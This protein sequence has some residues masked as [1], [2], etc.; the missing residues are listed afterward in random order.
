MVVCGK[1][2]L[3]NISPPIAGGDISGRSGGKATQGAG[4]KTMKKAVPLLPVVKVMAAPWRWA[5]R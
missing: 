4:G 5:M 1:I 2:S 3:K